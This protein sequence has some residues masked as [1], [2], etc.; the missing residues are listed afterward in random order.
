LGAEQKVQAVVLAAGVG[1][2]LLPLTT[3]TPK[4][5]LP[6]ANKPLIDYALDSIQRAGIRDILVVTGHMSSQTA[7][8]LETSKR[9]FS[10]KITCVNAERY[11]EGPLYSL[12]AAEKSVTDN[13]L[14]VPADLILDDWILSH[15]VANHTERDLIYL[16]TSA[17]RPETQR[18]VVLCYKGSKQD[19]SKILRFLPPGTPYEELQEKSEIQALVS[20]GAAV[21]PTRLFEYLHLASEKGA[22]RVADALSEF[23]AKTGLGRCFTISSQHYWFDIDT[24]NDMLEANSYILR[25]RYVDS[26]KQNNFFFDKET[27]LSVRVHTNSRQAQPAKIMGPTIIGKRCKIGEDSII[28]P[29]VSIQDRCVIGKHARISN[30]IILNESLVDDSAII[31]RAV[32]CGKETFRAEKPGRDVENGQ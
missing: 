4:S 15:L 26:G 8:Y 3:V 6:I 31:D 25:K 16:A 10:A 11:R 13:F 32:V 28:G 7:N 30:T 22:Q 21:C 5:L 2:R 23:A 20:I 19:N 9:T 24:I 18:T 29:Y 17:S 27:L 12:L 14:L 1:K